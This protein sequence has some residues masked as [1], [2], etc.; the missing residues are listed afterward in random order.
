MAQ[1]MF[2]TLTIE[3]DVFDT[4]NR[5]RWQTGWRHAWPI[6]LFALPPA[7]IAL[8]TTVW[9]D[10][11]TGQTRQTS[12]QPT[13]AAEQRHASDHKRELFNGSTQQIRNGFQETKNLA[14]NDNEPNTSVGRKQKYAKTK[15]PKTK[16]DRN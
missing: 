5:N 9:L 10:H 1:Q 16:Q 11:E 7:F 4:H 8:L 2:L 14:E 6:L 12:D 3:T 13:P 15:T